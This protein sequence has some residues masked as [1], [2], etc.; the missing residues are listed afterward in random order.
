MYM[1]VCNQVQSC[2]YR[3]KSQTKRTQGPP[4]YSCMH[5][6]EQPLLYTVALRVILYHICHA[7]LP[8]RQGDVNIDGQVS[9][10][11]VAKIQLGKIE[12]MKV[13]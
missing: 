3:V 10:S 5:V 11:E 4:L 1:H 13:T 6:S 7:P 2:S 12:L 9:E 8:S